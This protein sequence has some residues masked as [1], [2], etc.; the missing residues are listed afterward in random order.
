[1]IDPTNVPVERLFGMFKF[2]E[3]LLVNLQFELLSAITMAKFNPLN[4]KLEMFD[5]ETLWNAHAKID[6]FEARMRKEHEAQEANRVE[7]TE[8]VRDVVHIS[9]TF[10]MFLSYH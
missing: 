2:L 4:D 9:L 8:R 7:Y 3:Q 6:S 1:M 10:F 5:S